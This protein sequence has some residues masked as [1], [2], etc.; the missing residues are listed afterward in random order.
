MPSPS[1]KASDRR[2]RQK[3]TADGS[4]GGDGGG[5]GGAVESFDAR[6]S[7]NVAAATAAA[8][9]KEKEAQEARTH[10]T[11]LAISR[12]EAEQRTRLQAETGCEDGETSERTPSF[13]APNT[14][15]DASTSTDVGTL[16]QN[17]RS[18]AQRVE[19]ARSALSPEQLQEVGS[20][21]KN[22]VHM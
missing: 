11:M 15:Q 14:G 3:I 7:E 19:A 21:L 6:Q 10:A 17:V 18:L 12:A 22:I 4:D 2:V 8:A 20:L 5:D 16:M 13:Q 1:A 9:A